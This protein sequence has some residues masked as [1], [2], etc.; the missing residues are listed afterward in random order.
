MACPHVRFLP[1]SGNAA[2]KENMT[3]KCSLVA[4]AC[5]PARAPPQYCLRVSNGSTGPR[6]AR[7]E[8]RIGF[9]A[10]RMTEMRIT[11]LAA[12]ATSWHKLR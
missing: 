6:V 12:T 10:L 5:R 7:G 9:C 1:A 4:S 8:T 3:S 2:G 11:Q